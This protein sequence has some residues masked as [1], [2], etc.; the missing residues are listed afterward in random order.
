MTLPDL[1][2][3]VQRAA[4]RRELQGVARP[5]RYTGIAFA[6][7]GVMLAIAQRK[8]LPEMPTAIPMAAI[9]L[10]AFNMLAAIVIRTRYHQQR[11][12]G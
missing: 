5:L 1:K 6:L 8:W 7:L 9:V 4:Y 10:G 2:D 11:M 12:R 3:P